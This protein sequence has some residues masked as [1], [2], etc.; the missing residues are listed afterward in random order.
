MGKLKEE[1]CLKK[2]GPYEQ[3]RKQM[4]QIVKDQDHRTG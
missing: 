1:D 4:G 3:Q 2:R